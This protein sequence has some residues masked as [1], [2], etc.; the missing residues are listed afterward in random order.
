[1]PLTWRTPLTLTFVPVVENV[2]TSALTFVPA[3]TVA[4]MT[5]PLIVAITSLGSDGL[6]DDMNENAVNAFAELGAIATV[7]VYVFVVESAAVTTYV[8]GF[9]KS[10]AVTP[11][12]CAVVPTV[13]AVPVD[14]NAAFSAVTFVP[15]GTVVAIVVPLM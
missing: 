15:F 13:T 10:F 9:V 1:M 3:G 7:M 11:L 5:L 4:T 14:E 12:T 8:I 2:A 6:S